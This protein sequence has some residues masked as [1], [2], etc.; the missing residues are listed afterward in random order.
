IN[1]DYIV[2]GKNIINSFNESYMARISPPATTGGAASINWSRIFP[3][4]AFFRSMLYED[5]GSA[6]LGGTGGTTNSQVL[7][8]KLAGLGQPYKPD[9]CARPPQSLFSCQLN[10]DSVIFSGGHTSKAGTRYGVISKWEYI[11][12]DG[13]RFSTYD[14]L[15]VKR[16]AHKYSLPLPLLYG[17]PVKLIVTNN[18]FCTDTLTL[19]PFGGGPTGI[20][21]ATAAKVE[22]KLYPQPMQEEAILELKNYNK[23]EKLQLEVTDM[24]GRKVAMKYQQQKPGQWKLERGSLS[25]GLYVYRL[26]SVNKVVAQGKIV[27]D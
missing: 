17:T 27:I 3:G 21:E 15:E 16:V 24:L 10:P 20:T 22:V 4:G 12:G 6:V 23:Q 8:V 11:F 13:Q 14:S 1:N 9:Y 19:Y 7:A 26:V 2:A 18:L 5:N 25:K